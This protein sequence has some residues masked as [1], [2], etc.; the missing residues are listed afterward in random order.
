MGTLACIFIQRF[1]SLVVLVNRRGT[2]DE[3][4]LSTQQQQAEKDPRVSVEDG[5]ERGKAGFEA[6]ASQG[7][8]KADREWLGK[9]K[10]DSPGITGLFVP[11]ITDPFTGQVKKCTPR[12]LFSTDA[13]IVWIIRA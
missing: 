6:P 10:R 13:R 7:S 4:N 12:D 9:P 1:L 3:E 8:K 11:R 2:C 5:V